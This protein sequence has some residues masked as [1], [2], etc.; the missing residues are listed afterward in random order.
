MCFLFFSGMIRG[1]KR[2]LAISL[3]VTFLYGSMVYLLGAACGSRLLAALFTAAVLFGTS[4]VQMWLP[5]RSA[6]ITDALIALLV[7]G[8][9]AVLPAGQPGADAVPR[10]PRL[11]GRERRLR[12]WQREQ[13]RVLG[14]E[15]D[16]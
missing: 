3:L 14:I 12:D 8:V 5:G 16:R 10:P 15:T 11:T 7:A 2:L 9:F 4:W 13:A 6:E 1:D